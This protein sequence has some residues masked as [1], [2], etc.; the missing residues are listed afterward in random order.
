M[1]ARARPF[2]A[3]S[4][5]EPV[6]LDEREIE[7]PATG[8]RILLEYQFIWNT[9]AACP[10]HTRARQM[11]NK[12]GASNSA[13]ITGPAVGLSLLILLVLCVT[14]YFLLGFAY[15]RFVKGA[16]GL[17]QIPNIGFWREICSP[18]CGCCRTEKSNVRYDT[19]SNQPDQEVDPEVAGGDPEEPD[20]EMVPM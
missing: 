5:G 17:G 15:L 10:M 9:C 6:F 14:L 7:D 3:S 8:L 12:G 16:V 18:I 13:L 20:D 4:Q 11:C 2:L 1:R 19:M